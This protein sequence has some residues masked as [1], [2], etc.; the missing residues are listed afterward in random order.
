MRVPTMDP[1]VGKTAHFQY[2]KKKI[3][4]RRLSRKKK[5]FIKI[6]NSDISI[7]NF[8]SFHRRVPYDVSMTGRWLTVA[9]GG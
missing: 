7:E 1:F 2:N 3:F 4:Q 6:I 8:D 5:T 9:D